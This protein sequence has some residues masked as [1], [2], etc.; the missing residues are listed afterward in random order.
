M[1]VD[2][3]L[4]Q[5][6]G[7]G[8][9]VPETSDPGVGHPVPATGDPPLGSLIG[10]LNDSQ[11]S[12]PLLPLPMPSLSQLSRKRK[13]HLVD[14][15][16]PKH[17]LLAFSLRW[18]WEYSSCSYMYIWSHQPA[19][20]PVKWAKSLK[21][22]AL[23]LMMTRRQRNYVNHVNQEEPVCVETYEC[24]KLS[25]CCQ[26]WIPELGL[27]KPDRETLLNPAGWLTDSIVDAAQMLLKNTSPVPGLE[28]VA[29]GLTMS[30]TIQ[31]GDFIQILNAGKGHWVTA[32]S[33]ETTHPVVHIYDSL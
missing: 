6:P 16:L 7:V 25:E 1:D 5:D 18:W 30:F 13:V 24:K 23:N 22:N 17:S 4:G 10:S 26:S 32:S 33:I 11:E 31:H 27:S 2:E 20:N 19:C 8:Y 3:S 15:L 9:L 29:C 12:I 14:I 21:T 28:F